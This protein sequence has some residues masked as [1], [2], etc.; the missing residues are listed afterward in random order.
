MVDPFM[1]DASLNRIRT[2]SGQFAERASDVSKVIEH[3]DAHLRDMPGKI[4]VEIRE[5]P[6]AVGVDRHFDWGIWFTDN[7]SEE[8]IDGRMPE[9]LISTS[10]KRKIRVFPLL[11]KLLDE[12]EAEHGRQ[13]KLIDDAGAVLF[14]RIA[15]GK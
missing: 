2:K 11:P 5:G 12:I 4:P 10:I 7:D 13:L 6:L 15:E 8:T 9:E 14:E 1:L 3:V